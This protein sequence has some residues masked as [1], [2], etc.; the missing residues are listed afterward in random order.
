MSEDSMRSEAYAALT[1]G[2]AQ[3]FQ[4]DD[5]PALYPLMGELLAGLAAGKRR[6]V[7]IE[8]MV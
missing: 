4:L 3:V 8:E 1:G 2:Q 6:R 5:W 7:S